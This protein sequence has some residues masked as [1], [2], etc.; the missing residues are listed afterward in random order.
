VVQRA[1]PTQWFAAI[2]TLVIP[3]V[4]NMLPKSGFSFSFIKEFRAVNVV[5]HVG[6]VL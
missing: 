6:T 2:G 1:R 5:F 4:K 3:K